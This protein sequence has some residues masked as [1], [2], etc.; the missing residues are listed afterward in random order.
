MTFIVHGATGAQGRPVHDIVKARG[1]RAIAAVRGPASGVETA[2]V[3]LA[4]RDALAALYQGASGVFVHLPVGPPDA[5]AR[6]ASAVVHGIETARPARVVISTSGQIVDDDASPL[7]ASAESPIRQLID[8]V[9]ASGVSAAIVAPRLFLENLL[10]PVVQDGLRREGILRYPL[11]R[12][13]PVSWS[14]HLD[15]AEVAAELLLASEH[16]GIV[17]V[18]SLPPLTGDDLARG[19][20]TSLERDVSYE[21]LTPED[22][23]GLIRPLFGAEAAAP[24]VALYSTLGMCTDHSIDEATSA[25]RLLG[26]RPRSVANWLREATA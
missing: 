23:G 4:D 25:Q 16:T 21:S 13:L 8:G 5:G 3:D 26:L 15:V 14:S 20:Q 18:G 9:K 12:T 17:G 24:V 11:P 7:Q 10:L 22:F 6:Y 1:G 19:L 2:K